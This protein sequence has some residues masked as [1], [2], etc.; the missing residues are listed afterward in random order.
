M[1][2]ASCGVCQGPSFSMFNQPLRDDHPSGQQREPRSENLNTRDGFLR[3]CMWRSLKEL[4]TRT[5]E[6]S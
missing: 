2:E 5:A 1:S 6:A 4:L 3:A